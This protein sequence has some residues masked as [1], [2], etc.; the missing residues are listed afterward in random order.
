MSLSNLYSSAR[1][2][3]MAYQA[4]TNVTGQNIVVDGGFLNN[5]FSLYRHAVE[6]NKA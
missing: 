6:A 1:R 2:S 5:T 3:L 4:A